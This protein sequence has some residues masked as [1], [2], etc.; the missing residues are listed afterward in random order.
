MTYNKANTPWTC[1]CDTTKGFTKAGDTCVLTSDV[2]S[3]N[4]D[5][6]V[7]TIS[8]SLDVNY[9][10]YQILFPMFFVFNY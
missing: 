5:S 8:Y 9:F 3:T 7:S 2:S 4:A 1:D 10:N 6:S